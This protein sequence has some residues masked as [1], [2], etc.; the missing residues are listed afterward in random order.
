LIGTASIARSAAAATASALPGA[1]A[2]FGVSAC[3][4]S[5]GFATSSVGN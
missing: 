2:T 1:G 5:N 3:D 4:T